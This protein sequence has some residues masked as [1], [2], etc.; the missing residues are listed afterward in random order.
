MRLL[1]A[2]LR[3]LALRGLLPEGLRG[4]LRPDRA[5]NFAQATSAAGTGYRPIRDAALGVLGSRDAATA[6]DDPFQQRL[7]VPVAPLAALDYAAGSDR[8]FRPVSLAGLFALQQQ[9]PAARLVAGATEVGVDLNKKFKPFPLLISTEGVPELTAIAATAAAWRIG[10]AATLTAIEEALGAEYPSLAKMLRVFASRQIRSRATLGGNLA[11]A[12]PI[13]D[14]APVLMTLEA[15]LVLASPAGERTVLL[16]DFFTGYRQTVLQPGEII[17][18][19]VLPRSP[20]AGLTP[21][22]GAGQTRRADFL[23]VSKRRELDIS[24]VAG[25]FCLD[26]DTAGIVRRA[27]IAYGGV[28]ASPQ[29]ARRAEQALE[30]RTLAAAAAAVAEALRGNSSRSTTPAAAPPT[31]AAWSSVSGK[32]SCRVSRASLRMGRWHSNPAPIGK[33]RMIRGPSR[34][35]AARV[36]SRAAPFMPTTWASAGRCWTSGR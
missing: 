7:Q 28:A 29:R 9:Y 22:R 11:T 24:I 12:S 14:S 34:M 10:A 5:T 1:H 17:R 8:F 2:G 4:I 23:K 20:G 32:N 31:G 19:I 30:G 26:C 35:T 3:R 15:T 25:A 6:G 33:S 21:G 36:T 13:G 27:R 16:A 18:E